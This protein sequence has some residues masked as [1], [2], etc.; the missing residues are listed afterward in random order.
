MHDVVIVGGG[1]HAKVVASVLSSLPGY[2]ILGYSDL[3]DRGLLRGDPYLGNDDWLANFARKSPGLNLVIGVGQVGLGMKRSE[4]WRTF[5]TCGVCFPTIVSLHAT[6]SREARCGEAC[7]V[8]SGAVVNP[9]AAAGTGVIINTNCTIEHDVILHD[10]VH[11]ASGATVC[12]GV[13][14]GTYSM[15]GAGAT[16]IEGVK[17]PPCS[18]IGAGATVIRSIAEPGVYAGSPARRI[19]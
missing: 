11:V 3:E 17:V 12:G 14:V 15:I 5:Q 13:E 1:G 19:R 9:D 18:I 10:W 8:M 7:T 2:R 16:L 4:L 6:M